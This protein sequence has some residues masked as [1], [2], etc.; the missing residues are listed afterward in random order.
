MEKY[1][2]NIPVEIKKI[3]IDIGLSYAAHNQI[4]G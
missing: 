4:I 3:K 2:Q 1:L